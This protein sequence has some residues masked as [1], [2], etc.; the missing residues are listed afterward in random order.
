[1]HARQ[2]VLPAMTQKDAIDKHREGQV[3]FA[4]VGAVEVARGELQSQGAVAGRLGFRIGRSKRDI[5]LPDL[6]IHAGLLGC[7]GNTFLHHHGA[8]GR[9]AEKT[10]DCNQYQ[11]YRPK[12]YANH[13]KRDFPQ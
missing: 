8:Q 10:G 9:Y 6:Y 7:D 4:L 2:G 13:G 11:Y 1:M 3:C 12:W 5:N